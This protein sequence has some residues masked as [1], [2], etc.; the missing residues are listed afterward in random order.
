MTT[1]ATPEGMFFS[2]ELVET[3]DGVELVQLTY[4][5]LTNDPGS[6]ARWRNARRNLAGYDADV[7]ELRPGKKT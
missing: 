5:L 1:P 4:T 3:E 2:E 6:I 7:L